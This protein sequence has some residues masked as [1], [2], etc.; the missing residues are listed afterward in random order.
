[1]NIGP[2]VRVLQA[3]P[4]IEPVPEEIA[5]CDGLPR[6]VTAVESLPVPVER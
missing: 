1:M 6:D 4:V 2:V 3:E 5:L